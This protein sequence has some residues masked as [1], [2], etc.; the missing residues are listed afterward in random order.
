[1]QIQTTSDCSVISATS[2]QIR[3]LIDGN[4]EKVE[5]NLEYNCCKDYQT[6]ILPGVEDCVWTAGGDVFF[7]SL[8][9]AT[10]SHI[11]GIQVRKSGTFE[12]IFDDGAYDMTSAQD[13][14]DMENE[15][16]SWLASNG[17]GNFEIEMSDGIEPN[18]AFKFIFTG[19]DDVE[20]RLFIPYP[21]GTGALGVNTFFTCSG[22]QNPKYGITTDSIEIYPALMGQDV[23]PD[24]VYGVNI[25]VVASDGSVA[26]ARECIL[27]DCDLKC[28]VAESTDKN[29]FFIYYLLKELGDCDCDCKT[30]CDLL[31]LSLDK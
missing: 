15:V 29:A 5:V 17:G 4:I 21:P 30:M 9:S 6:E 8:G 13:R 22:T 26:E 23:F 1:M 2:T 11:S 20:P 16:N 14:A 12:W 7:S 24:G 31:R 28:R 18:S 10:M 27:I 19:L 3:D 25:R